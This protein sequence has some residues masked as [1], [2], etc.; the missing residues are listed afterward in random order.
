MSVLY[1]SLKV[2]LNNNEHIRVGRSAGMFKFA[3]KRKS[4]TQLN[5]ESPN[6]NNSGIIFTELNIGINLLKIV[7]LNST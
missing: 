4:T 7:S 1:L 3:K 2:S 5:F 6:S